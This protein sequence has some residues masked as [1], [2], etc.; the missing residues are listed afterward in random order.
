MITPRIAS[1]GEGHQDRRAELLEPHTRRAA[2]ESEGV[3]F[4]AEN[5]EGPSVRL[6]KGKIRTATSAF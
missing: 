6:K 4:I 1:H 5:G 2:L 3:E